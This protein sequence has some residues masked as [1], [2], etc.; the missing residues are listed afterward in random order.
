MRWTAEFRGVLSGLAIVGVFLLL[1]I[2]APLMIPGQELLQSLRFHIA[3]MIFGLVV[4]LF[5]SGAWWRGLVM[6]ILVGISAGQGGWIIYQQQRERLPIVADSPTVRVLSYNVL[7]SN[8]LGDRLADYM[9]KTAPDLMVVMESA[10]IRS[11]LSRLAAEFPYH[12][13]CDLEGRNCDLMVFSRTPLADVNVYKLPWLN[14][15]RLVTAK[16]TIGGRD[17]T[18][19]GLHLTKPYFDEIAWGELQFARQVLRRIDGPIILAGDFNAAAWS[20]TIARFVSDAG[21]APPP[22]Y[23][24]TWPVEL[25]MLGVPIDNMYT[26]GSAVISRIDA[27]PDAIGSNHLGILAD[28]ALLPPA[29]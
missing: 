7:A 20:E 14:R 10:A 6:L 1:T 27:I 21:L 18:M 8:P 22:N 25:G 12:A 28:V 23:P 29:T 15:L 24:G 9:I 11:Q 2:N 13:G 26:R 19:V 4:L 17:V 16:T 5:I 3:A